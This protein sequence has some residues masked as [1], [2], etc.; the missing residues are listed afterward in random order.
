ML[1]VNQINQPINASFSRFRKGK[2]LVDM[3]YAAMHFAVTHYAV[4]HYA[5]GVA[6]DKSTISQI[7]L[8]LWASFRLSLFLSQQ[9]C[10]EK[11]FRILQNV[12][13]VLE[14]CPSAGSQIRIAATVITCRA[15]IDEGITVIR[16]AA[17][18]D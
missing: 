16:E 5:F 8:S 2:M 1:D 18:L 4:M 11:R 9:R 6:G 15:F 10:H 17:H 3:H 12:N 7:L 14:S 13:L